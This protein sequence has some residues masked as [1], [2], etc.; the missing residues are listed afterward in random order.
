MQ[1]P[2]AQKTRWRPQRQVIALATLGIFVAIVVGSL[3]LS[4]ASQMSTL[5]RELEELIETRDRLEQTNEQLRA[6]IAGLQGMANLQMRAQELGFRFADRSDIEYLVVNGY[7]PNRDADIA[8]REDVIEDI[9]V[10]DE[11]LIGWLQQQ[12]DSF[13]N[14]ANRE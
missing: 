4:Q 11:S 13:Q 3:Y 9:P 12:I 14:D 7:N 10:Y 5:G 1:T 6:E 8:P 2:H